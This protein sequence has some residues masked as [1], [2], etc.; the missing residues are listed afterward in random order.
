MVHG[1]LDGENVPQ[2][3]AR[4]WFVGARRRRGRSCRCWR[5]CH[6]DE[7]RVSRRQKPAAREGEGDQIVQEL[8]LRPGPVAKL[9]TNYVTGS[10]AQALAL[11]H[12]LPLH[13]TP[14][15]RYI[16]PY[17]HAYSRWLHL[18]LCDNNNYPCTLVV[19][20]LDNQ[21]TPPLLSLHC[22]RHQQTFAATSIK[23]H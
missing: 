4:V 23:V 2:A 10:D 13:S 1:R 14:L 11:T 9:D 12:S 19:S 8:R 5:V 16:H 20:W 18:T 7:S 15:H 21:P 17:S 6:E 3:V 22:L